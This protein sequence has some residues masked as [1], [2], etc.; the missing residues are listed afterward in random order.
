[1]ADPQWQRTFRDRMRGFQARAAHPGAAAL[2]VKV[3]VVSGCFHRDHS[4]HAYRL[5]DSQPVPPDVEIVEHESGPE[6][7]VILAAAT[8]GV[9]LAKSVIDLIAAILK[10]RAEG[11]KKGDRPDDPLELIARRSGDGDQYREELILRIGHTE[12][13]D[14]VALQDQIEKALQRL[15]KS[16]QP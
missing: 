2:S 7:L 4:P 10:A 6:L 8:A 16:D 14:P 9:T 3:R 15:F 13:V 1:M 12:P 11:V 5:L